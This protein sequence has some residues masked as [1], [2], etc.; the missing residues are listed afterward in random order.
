VT[1]RPRRARR[2][3]PP[4]QAANSFALLGLNSDAGLTDDQ[5]R[6]AWR[7]IAATTHPDRADGGDPERFALVAAAY[8]ELRTQSGRGEARATLIAA[9]A[10]RLSPNPVAIVAASGAT[11]AAQL[12][13]RVRLGRPVRLALRVLAAVAAG[14]AGF[15]AAGPGPAGPALA[16]GALTWLILTIRRDLSPP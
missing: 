1:G 4:G 3:A 12:L 9:A 11:P 5:V 2:S 15:L 10:A 6:A 14:L 8:T 16:T 13:A 7:R